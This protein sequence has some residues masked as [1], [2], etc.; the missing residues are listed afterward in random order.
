MC[1]VKLLFPE[2]DVPGVLQNSCSEKLCEISGEN[3]CVADLFRKADQ[4]L[5]WKST[6][7]QLFPWN[8]AKLLI[9]PICKFTSPG[10]YP[11]VF[12][13][14]RNLIRIRKV[15]SYEIFSCKDRKFMAGVFIYLK[16]VNRSS[17]VPK[18][19]VWCNIFLFIQEYR[20]AS[21]FFVNF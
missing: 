18:S 4:Q 17:D 5:Y 14:P 11:R 1:N 19:L 16:F 2:A 10:E 12:L 3:N 7:T 21:W 13:F 6:L 20:K 9:L 8:F 15:S